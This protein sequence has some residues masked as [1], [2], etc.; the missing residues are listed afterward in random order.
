MKITY[1]NK[2]EVEKNLD[3]YF[4]SKVDLNHLFLV[5]EIRETKIVN[6][7]QGRIREFR[8]S[9]VILTIFI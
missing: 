6:D 9:V 3:G 5:G 2:G 1:S 7:S 4:E 8:S